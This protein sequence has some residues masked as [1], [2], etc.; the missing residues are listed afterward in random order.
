ME[1]QN[2][3][4][5]FTD[6]KKIYPQWMASEQHGETLKEAGLCLHGLAKCPLLGITFQSGEHWREAK[7]TLSWAIQWCW[8]FTSFLNFAGQFPLC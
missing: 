2:G 6:A 4:Y 7:W 8:V 3:G 1:A 5:S